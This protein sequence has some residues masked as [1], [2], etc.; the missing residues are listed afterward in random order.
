MLDS[1]R[2]AIGTTNH[3]THKTTSQSKNIHRTFYI[4]MTKN[5]FESLILGSTYSAQPS[6][7]K[8]LNQ[9]RLVFTS[10]QQRFQKEPNLTFFH[11]CQRIF[12]I[13][14]KTY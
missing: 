10:T 6:S 11:R 5:I 2:L 3:S 9:I 1:E 4:W 12:D 7:K 14:P 8:L 13:F